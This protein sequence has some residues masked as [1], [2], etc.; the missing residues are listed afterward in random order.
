M[1][2]GPASITA[3]D[4]VL[5][6]SSPTEV[7]VILLLGRV[8]EVSDTAEGWLLVTADAGSEACSEVDG[9]ALLTEALVACDSI[10]A[11]VVGTTVGSSS[12]TV[13]STTSAAFCLRGCITVDILLRFRGSCGRLV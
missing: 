10:L 5:L 3:L 11:E 8:A 13:R 2:G 1:A 6:E 9:F 12:S 4:A 7:P